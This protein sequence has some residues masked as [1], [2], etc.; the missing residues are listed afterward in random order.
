[1]EKQELGLHNWNA[2]GNKGKKFT[3]KLTEISTLT[4]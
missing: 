4:H 3:E 1:M 2:K